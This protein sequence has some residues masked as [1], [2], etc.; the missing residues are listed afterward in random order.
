[1]AGRHLQDKFNSDKVDTLAK[2]YKHLTG[3]DTTF[4]F[5]DEQ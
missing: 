5:P 3:K 1:M 4:V 2:V